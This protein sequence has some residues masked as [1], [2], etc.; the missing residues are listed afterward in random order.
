M[1]ALHQLHWKGFSAPDN[2][3]QESLDQLEANPN[4]TDDVKKELMLF[5]PINVKYAPWQIFNFAPLQY[6]PRWE[7]E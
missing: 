6:P 4:L 2:N 1:E 7:L 5:I 3:S